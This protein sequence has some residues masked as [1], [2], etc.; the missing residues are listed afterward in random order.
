MSSG[1]KV[2]SLIAQMMGH[3]YVSRVAS[4]IAKVGNVVGYGAMNVG[5]FIG[6]IDY[7][8]KVFGGDL[9]EPCILGAFIGLMLL[10][11]L[12]LVAWYVDK[13][14]VIKISSN[15]WRSLKDNKK[16]SFKTNDN[17]DS[18]FKNN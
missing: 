12:H 18:L 1:E 8:G 11:L 4:I 2:G 6:G 10:L 14:Y 3:A 17:H 5:V 9:A 16:Y 15:H 7:Y 13:Q